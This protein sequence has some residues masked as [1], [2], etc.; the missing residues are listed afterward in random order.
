[1]S[2]ETEKPVGV[3]QELP[4]GSFEVR[5]QKCGALLFTANTRKELIWKA[6]TI[7]N[8]HC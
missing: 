5:C 6:V 4:D 8:H 3:F 2:E 7:Q 1:M